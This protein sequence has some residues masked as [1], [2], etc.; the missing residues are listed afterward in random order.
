MEDLQ[1]LDTLLRPYKC[2][3]K[4]RI[5]STFDGGY[6]LPKRSIRDC[7]RLLSFGVSTN[8]DFEREISLLNKSMI[9][10]M[11]DPFIGPLAD[12]KRLLKRFTGNVTPVRTDIQLKINTNYSDQKNSLFKDTLFRFFHWFGF[13]SF[14]ARKN[15]IYKKIGLSNKDDHLFTSLPTLF[16]KISS[17]KN[18]IIK[19][20]IEGYE[21]KVYKDLLNHAS[22]VSVLLLE[23]HYIESNKKE[24]AEIIQLLKTKGLF[25]MHIHGNNTDVLISNSTIPNTLELSFAKAD[26]IEQRIDENT[27]PIPGLDTPCNPYWED[28]PLDFLKK[29]A[30]DSNLA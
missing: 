3:D 2:E 8:I 9:I 22:Q 14:I 10:Q 7:S 12:F 26:Y 4:I 20:D 29:K 11:Y 27:Y 1:T 17:E 19:M 15:I 30:E 28:Y 25:L 21:Y 18:I 6:I 24:A 13:Y 16:K 5:G 23:L